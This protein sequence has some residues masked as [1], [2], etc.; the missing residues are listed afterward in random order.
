MYSGKLLVCFYG[1]VKLY[2]N[3]LQKKIKIERHILCFFGTFALAQINCY[4][5]FSECGKCTDSNNL[6]F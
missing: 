5:I 3:G 6:R 4:L 2:H 1:L